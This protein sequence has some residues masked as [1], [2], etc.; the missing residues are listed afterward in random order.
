VYQFF[1]QW[2][3]ADPAAASHQEKAYQKEPDADLRV[4][5]DGQLP[6]D[7]L[8]EGRF[9]QARIQERVQAWERLRPR[10]AESLKQFKE[11][12]LP[13]WQ[14]TLQVSWPANQS[15][16]SWK[17]SR[18]G[19]FFRSAS[20]QVKRDRPEAALNALYFT[21][22]RRGASRDYDKIVI[23]A[24]AKGGAVACDDSGAPTALAAQLIKRGYAVLALKNYS[25]RQEQD[26]FV[27]FYT[28]Y[29]RTQLQERVGDL[30]TLCAQARSFA[31]AKGRRPQVILWGAGRAGLWTLLAAPGADAVLADC[32]QLDPTVD[33]ALLAPDL[34][35]PGIRNVGAFEGGAMLAAPHPALLH[36]LKFSTTSLAAAYQAAGA[37][38]KLRVESS[39]LTDDD[40]VKW[41]ASLK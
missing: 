30:L 35:C 29:N 13:G 26:Q 21:P 1:N 22:L 15:Q 14:H 16:S 38:K 5:T 10:D 3:L 39:P 7:A 2:L 27:N 4:W 40:L 18:E 19:D 28:T 20:L 11:T 24:D 34:F 33:T 8:S 25:T 9:I 17:A 6:S 23:L 36:N 12:V 41:V 32:D 31:G 37:S